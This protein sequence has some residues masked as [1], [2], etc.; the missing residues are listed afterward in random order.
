ME[1]DLKELSM[2]IAA[3]ILRAN[4]VPGGVECTRAQLMLATPYS[5]ERN[6]GGRNKKSIA[7]TILPHLKVL[8]AAMRSE[9]KE[10][11]SD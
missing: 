11:G 2:Q 8:V 10:A 3:D 6:M 7:Q 4:A 1:V 9:S 5:G